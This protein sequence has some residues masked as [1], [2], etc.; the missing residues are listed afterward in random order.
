[1]KNLKGILLAVIS[2]VNTVVMVTLLM[3]FAVLK[4][5]LPIEAVRLLLSKVLVW[6]AE[7]WIQVNSMAYRLFHGD[8]IITDELPDLARDQWYLVVANHQSTA[9]IPIIQAVFN[10]KIPFLKFFLKKELIWVPFLGLAWWALDFPFMR[11]YSQSY[12]KK[13]P[14]MKGKDF[15][16]TKKSCEKFK[17]FPTSVISFIEGT[18]FTQQKHAKQKSPFQ[19]LLKPKAGGVANVMGSMG[20]EMKQLLLITVCYENNVPGM[21]DYLC[22]NFHGAEVKCE[23]IVI[24]DTLLNKNYQTDEKFKTE[25][26]KWS[27]QLWYK[28]DKKL[29]DFYERANI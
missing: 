21:W 22:G 7:M 17:S 6:I 23:K 8:K 4:L 1:M 2:I 10:K 12:L 27:H 13:H 29:K 3:V 9:D 15:E 28:Q 18:R 16:Q 19:Y 24:P 14:Q 25:L 20:T 11:R 26:F 5:I